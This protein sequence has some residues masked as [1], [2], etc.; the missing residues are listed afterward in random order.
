[1]KQS[2]DFKTIAQR[3][4]QRRTELCLS[5]QDVA[6][7][8]NMSKSTLQRYESGSIRNIPLQKLGVLASALNASPD[9]ILGL[10]DS[11]DTRIA[12]Q[13]DFDNFLE[14]G[15]PEESNYSKDEIEMLE[16]FKRLPLDDRNLIQEM[17][18][19]CFIRY[20]K[21]TNR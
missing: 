11:P 14:K 7:M 20:I 12:T 15:L 5:L 19:Y 1:M 8:T 13:A 21:R 17:V 4:K 3:I 16:Q 2:D 6:D 18:H 10:T 9:F